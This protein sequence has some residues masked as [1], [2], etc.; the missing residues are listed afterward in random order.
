MTFQNLAF[1]QCASNLAETCCNSLSGLSFTTMDV[2]PSSCLANNNNSAAYIVFNVTNGGGID[3]LVDG[4]ATSGFF[5]VAIFNIPPG[6][7]PCNIT[8]GDEITCSFAPAGGGCTSWGTAAA[9][10]SSNFAPI[11][12][13]DCDRILVLVENFSG[14]NNSFDIVIDNADADGGHVGP[15]E[16]DIPDAASCIGAPAFQIPNGTDVA[17]PGAFDGGVDIPGGVPAETGAD[18]DACPNAAGGTYTATCGACV[19]ATGVFDPAVAGVGTHTVTYEH[20]TTADQGTMGNCCYSTDVST[21]TINADPDPTLTCPAAPICTTDGLLDLMYADN[22]AASATNG[23]PTLAITGSGATFVDANNMFDP[24]AA[25]VGTFDVTYTLT[26]VDG[27]CE[28]VITCSI[29]VESCIDCPTI[30]PAITAQDICTGSDPDFATA[31]TEVNATGNNIGAYTYFTDAGYTTPYAGPLTNLTCVPEA[32]T[33]Y[34]RLQCADPN[35]AGT[36][37][38]FS[39]FSFTVN[40][41]PDANNFVVTE[42]PGACN[43]SASVSITAENGDECFAET[44]VLPVDPGCDNPDDVQDLTYAFDPGFIAACNLMFGNT[45]P[46]SCATT[47]F[48]SDPAF[49]CPPP[50]ISFCDDLLVYD[51]LPLDNNNVP[52]ATGVFSGS[53]AIYVVGS[54]NPGDSPT[55][56]LTTAPVGIPFTLEYTVTAPGCPPITTASGCAVELFIDCDANGGRF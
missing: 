25:G 53:G 19:S 50:M 5:D 7:N 31:E 47:S 3:A 6:T 26:S 38:E 36:A 15:P 55:I 12:V 54:T 44:G 16:A 8:A 1:G 27:F 48:S 20:Y 23:A 22:N 24:A 49:T 56:D 32:V 4:D 52:G 9:G 30:A 2:N 10:C 46:A 21:I 28:G 18:A 33:I 43:V 51:L 13:A 14:N 17:G 41:Y 39:D 37:D 35:V 11:P 45:V 29:T 42:T 34:G 40:V